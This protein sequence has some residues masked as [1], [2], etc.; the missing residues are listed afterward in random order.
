MTEK[1]TPKKHTHGPDDMPEFLCRQCHPEL[2]RKYQPKK[3]D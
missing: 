2:S 3:P 1:P